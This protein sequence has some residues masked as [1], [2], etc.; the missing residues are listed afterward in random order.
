MTFM[1]DVII[2]STHG[3]RPANHLIATGCVLMA[4]PFVLALIWLIVALSPTFAAYRSRTALPIQIAGPGEGLV[5]VAEFSGPTTIDDQIDRAVTNAVYGSY[6][7]AIFTGRSG[8]I[9]T[10][11]EDALDLGARYGAGIV[12]WGA[13]DGTA[14][15]VTIS[16][17][18]PAD[19]DEPPYLTLTLPEDDPGGITFVGGFLWS[20]LEFHTNPPSYGAWNAIHALET[21]LHT[22]ERQPVP[23]DWVAYYYALGQIANGQQGLAFITVEN[24]LD[25]SPPDSPIWPFYARLLI[26]SGRAEDAF[27]VV[28]GLPRTTDTLR[29]L[30]LTL[31]VQTGRYEEAAAEIESLLAQSPG[32]HD[33]L[34]QYAALLEDSGDPAAA[35]EVYTG[36]IARHPESLYLRLER[37]RLYREM[38]NINSALADLDSIPPVDTGAAPALRQAVLQTRADLLLES[39]DAGAALS[40]YRQLEADFPA[41]FDAQLGIGLAYWLMGDEPQARETWEALGWNLSN[42]SG[43]RIVALELARRGYPAPAADVLQSALDMNGYEHEVM[44]V[45]AVIALQAGDYDEAYRLYG[46]VDGQI[47][48]VDTPYSPTFVR[49]WAD[50]ALASGRAEIA[51]ALYQRYL[52]ER[53]SAP[54]A[55]EVRALLEGQ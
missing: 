18:S 54:D 2:S 24:A 52:L 36:L 41:S 48:Y 15:E 40:A 14:A 35:V 11:H 4:V 38:G 27:A 7:N 17:A 26:Q 50:A 1:K 37:A 29:D 46:E 10:S 25:G 12:V 44:Y 32:D 9:I 20:L 5:I 34:L 13:S 53:P 21:L 47:T 39:G 43:I 45:Q 3:D 16:F 23:M 49:E 28:D 8:R 19:E 6:N 55:D 30:Y 51:I 31:L 42:T 22:G 33:L